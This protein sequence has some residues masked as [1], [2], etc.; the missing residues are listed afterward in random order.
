MFVL[1]A[2]YLAIQCYYINM[3]SEQ[4]FHAIEETQILRQLSSQDRLFLIGESAPLEYIKN[5]VNIHQQINNNY[6]Y[7]L[8]THELDRLSIIAPD[9]S[10][11]RAI[12]IVSLQDED[13]LFQKVQ[14]NAKQI[15]LP[16]LKLFGDVFIN[17]LCHRQL[18]Q[19]ASNQIKKPPISY[20]IVTT[21][22]SGSTYLCDLLDS[23]GIAGHPSEHLRQAALELSLDCNF[24]Y[25][26]LL[27]NLL[28]YRT[29][30]NG[31]FGTKFISHF[32]F[33]FQ[34][35]KPD[36]KQIFN[37]IDRFILLIREDKVAQAVSL[38]LAQKTQI[39]HIRNSIKNI[40]YKSKLE[41]V[42][43]DDALLNDVE[44]KYEFLNQQEAR[45]KKI[46]VANKV[47]HMLLIYEDILKDPE[48]QINRILDFLKI[49]RPENY[50]M[51]INS[52][53]KK[54]PSNISQE[55]IDQF[56]HRKSTAY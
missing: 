44:Q 18:L 49:A 56:K 53:I 1:L 22:R 41:D 50:V 6:Y 45:L 34:Q 9:L 5:F 48:L 35:A 47:E 3:K 2:K 4:L 20:A 10:Y 46:L 30:E 17:L 7:D 32:F 19:P 40:S 24:N 28:Q 13:L 39:W 51:N 42:A 25:L 29:S 38:V 31:V 36:F 43:I 23:T 52:E 12:I 27:H 54:M 37:S 55:I 33:D 11:Y 15:D 16:I 14:Q 8:S 21:P 26:K